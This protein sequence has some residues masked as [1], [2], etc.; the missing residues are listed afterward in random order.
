MFVSAIKWVVVSSAFLS[1]FI[2]L[3]SNAVISS[4][5]RFF[6]NDIEI[7]I[8][9]I[10]DSHANYHP[11]KYLGTD[12]KVSPFALIKGF[13][14]ETISENK[15]TLLVSAGDTMEKGSVADFLSN[16]LS[17]IEI[18][19]AM[20][21]DYL[22][23]GNHDF[24][25]GLDTVKALSQRSAK[26][27][28]SANLQLMN[29]KGWAKPYAIQDIDGIKVAFL[30]LTT[31]PYNEKNESY[32]GAIYNDVDMAVRFDYVETV[33]EYVNII[34][35]HADILILLTHLGKGI[36]RQIAEQVNGIDLIIGGHSHSFTYS[37]EDVLKENVNSTPIVQAASNSL[38]LGLSRLWI[39]PESKTVDFVDYKAH[40]IHP[41]FMTIDKEIQTFIESTLAKYAPAWDN[42]VCDQKFDLNHHQLS[43]NVREAV[44]NAYDVDAVFISDE[45]MSGFSNHGIKTQQDFKNNYLVEI[46]PPGT[47]GWTSLYSVSV[48][49]AD[50]KKIIE[51]HKAQ[52]LNQ[53]TPTEINDDQEYSLI[54][55]KKYVKNLSS[56]FDVA[57]AK[58]QKHLLE[59]FELV[60]EH[61]AQTTTS[62]SSPI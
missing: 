16:G 10:N 59:M 54:T 61:C 14:K 58:D 12:K 49:G 46:Q 47:T 35:P 43:I 52:H 60:T 56:Y 32:S 15:N 7:S 18:F 4:Y 57:S 40:W 24:A 44:K 21:F 55:H 19:E 50:L 28:L 53:F 48:N 3:E 36:D 23:L 22:T 5:Y 1:V 20:G 62:W 11:I 29:D 2:Y 27:T 41:A 33:K 31:A 9:H 30:G 51:G 39:D 37:K 45:M 8:I 17:T 34:K 42:K 38:L 6:T 26:T 25:Y 13:H